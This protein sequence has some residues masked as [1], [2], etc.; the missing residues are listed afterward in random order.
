MG[1]KKAITRVLSVLGIDRNSNSQLH[2]CVSRAHVNTRPAL[3]AL[4]LIDHG[5]LPDELD[6]T[7]MAVLLA[8]PASYASELANLF[9]DILALVV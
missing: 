8:Y 3:G 2:D 5:N 4:L 9:D 1:A 6:C 7:L